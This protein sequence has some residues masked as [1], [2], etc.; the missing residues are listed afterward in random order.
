MQ[1]V[2]AVLRQALR[3]Q[4]AAGSPIR[5]DKKID[6][7]LVVPIYQR[8]DRPVVQIIEPAADQRES[9]S[10]Q[11]RDRRREIELAAEPRLD[12]MLIGSRHICEMGGQHRARMAGYHLFGKKFSL[13][14]RVVL[15]CRD[16]GHKGSG[17]NRG[18]ELKP[19]EPWLLPARFDIVC[20]RFGDGVADNATYPL[21][22]R[23]GSGV[24]RSVFADA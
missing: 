23:A 10:R 7:M 11:I 17:G 8:R 14:R 21:L 2:V 22:Q 9:R 1:D 5:P 24:I 16:P 3:R 13:G 20:R 15:D 6:Y 18:A 4:S 19:S 12:R